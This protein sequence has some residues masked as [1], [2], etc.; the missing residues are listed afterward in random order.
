[1]ALHTQSGG[2]SSE[3]RDI[4]EEAGTKL[5]QDHA[6]LT[7]VIDKLAIAIN[8][9]YPPQRTQMRAVINLD[10]S[11]PSV[12]A[13]HAAKRDW[14]ERTGEDPSTD[15]YYWE[16]FT[17]SLRAGLLEEVRQALEQNPDLVDCSPSKFE[18]H[19]IYHLEKFKQRKKEES[20]EEMKDMEVQLLKLQLKEARQQAVDK[21]KDKKPAK[22]LVTQ[23]GTA[24][25]Q[26]QPVPGFAPLVS[27][28]QCG[29]PSGPGPNYWTPS[30]YRGGYA[31]GGRGRG[32]GVYGRGRGRGQ[33]RGGWQAR[34]D[35]GCFICGNIDHW[36]RDCPNHN[37]GGYHITP[38]VQRGP[39][40][41]P[42]PPPVPLQQ[43]PLGEGGTNN[44]TPQGRPAIN[45]KRRNQY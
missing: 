17:A 37:P 21:K 44:R 19:L 18:K 45:H 16:L 1:M 42:P 12:V 8:K 15:P 40:A 10:L 28:P 24:V 9:K 39:P 27:D 36:A 35:Q 25:P 4:E 6:P 14:S 5:C 30:Y 43:F 20:K 7:G 13:L 2:T 33:T 41:G 11:K 22:V 32:R 3:L 26:W 34:G 38:Q 31:R 23:E 29:P